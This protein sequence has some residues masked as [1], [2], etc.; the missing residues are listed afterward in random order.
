MATSDGEM[1][2]AFHRLF[3][4][5]ADS[6]LV[7]AEDGRTILD[8]N[9]RAAEVMQPKEGA[10]IGADIADYLARD[11]RELPAFAKAIDNH[12]VVWT[13][14]FALPGGDDGPR[15]VGVTASGF[16]SPAGRFILLV[17][18]E[19]MQPKDEKE[20]ADKTAA[21]SASY[22]KERMARFERAL[23]HDIAH[24]IR[25]PITPVAIHVALLER[26]LAP[27]LNDDDKRSFQMIK[28]SLERLNQ[29]VI[30]IIE[31]AARRP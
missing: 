19:G 22:Y 9:P 21:D 20:R 14:T 25:T 28:K 8:A 2:P 31:A 18:H 16:E 12:G 1:L 29:H 23:V 4:H 15:P 6:I 10:L 13:D 24:N 17:L 5:S 3:E 7:L 27:L 11:V 30:E 26:N